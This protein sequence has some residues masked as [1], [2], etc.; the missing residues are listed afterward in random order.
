MRGLTAYPF[1]VMLFSVDD[2]T[3]LKLN[4]SECVLAVPPS[5]RV[6]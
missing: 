1:L 6:C 5:V 4:L 3:E 2:T